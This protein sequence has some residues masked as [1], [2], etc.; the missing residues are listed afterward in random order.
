[1]IAFYEPV[2]GQHILN[3]KET[4]I[5]SIR[6]EEVLIQIKASGVNRADLLQRRG[7]YPPPENVT[8]V[9]G[10]EC[11]GEIVQVGTSVSGWK[12]GDRVCVLLA[13]GGYAEFVSAHS[14]MVL[15]IPESWT[16]EEAAA[17][18]EAFYTAYY[19]LFFIGNLSGSQSVLIHAGG[20]GVG[21]AAIQL[22]H[23]HSHKIFTTV[24]SEEKVLACRKLGADY[25]INYNNDDFQKKIYAIT[26]GLGVD[27]IVDVVGAK[28]L[29]AN[30][31][32]LAYK[33]TLVIIG[34]M[35]GAKSSL[36]LA[37]L[38]DKNLTIRS[39]TLRHQP[40]SMKSELTQL[41]SRHVLPLA[42]SGKIKPVVDSVFSFNDVEQAHQRML[43]NKNFGKIVLT[44][45]K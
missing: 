8:S 37:V 12:P 15:R 3:K 28:Y 21:T 17:F 19:N 26:Q 32:C 24:G 7:L 14:S 34:L 11:A 42:E 25:C 13:G 5:P 41:V 45:R 16:F 35:G 10:L 23:A 30:L 29:E 39:T 2:S 40:L 31:R 38:L 22:A 36:N 18:P 6:A 9:M 27:V 20:S 33:G 4:S 1:M 44:W 43:E